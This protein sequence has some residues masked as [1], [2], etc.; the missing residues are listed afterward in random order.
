[1]SV[2]ERVRFKTLPNTDEAAFLEAAQ[3]SFAWVKTQPGFM[4][5]TLVKDGD[6]WEDL[7]YWDGQASAQA[8]GA[9]FMASAENA[10]YGAMISPGT[11]VMA[12]L[13]QM[14]AI[15]AAG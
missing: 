3:A 1:M 8:G 4:Y 14:L 11:V 15:A 10:A 9:A 7:V 6:H 2:L 5:R 13:P 12:H